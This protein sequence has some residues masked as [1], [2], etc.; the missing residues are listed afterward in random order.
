MRCWIR[1]RRL[2]RC[3]RD[4]TNPHLRQ[5]PVHAIAARWGFT[6]PA[7]FSRIFRA[8]Y[9]LSPS[10]YRHNAFS[11]EQTSTPRE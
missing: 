8:A 4:L 10:D 11:R 9:G 3:R 5:R 7:H 2:E 1:Q 6:D